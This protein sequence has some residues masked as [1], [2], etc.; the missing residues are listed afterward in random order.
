MLNPGG[1]IIVDVA[2]IGSFTTKKEVT[3]IEHNLM[4][5]FCS[6]EDWSGFSEPL[7]I[8]TII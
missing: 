1:H 3:I 5:G 8:L 7:Y 6:A 2:G 4:G